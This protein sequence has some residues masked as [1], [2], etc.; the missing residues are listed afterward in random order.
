MKKLVVLAIAIL[1]SSISFGQEIDLGIKAGANFASITDAS[2]VSNK[3]G[4]LAGAFAGIKFSDK[5]G[6]QVDLLYSQQGAEFDAGEFD[7]N[8]AI[9]PVVLKYYLVQG[10]NIQAGPQFG[11]IVDDNIKEIYG[12]IEGAVKA[13]SFDLTAVVGAGYDLPMGLRID[14]RYNFGLSDIIDGGTESN[15]NSVVSLALG[16]SFL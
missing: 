5:V 12:D 9:V 2:E 15:K 8:Y 1:V 14:A 16:Y 7:L 13:E 3:T 11:F 4:F 10:L 6:V